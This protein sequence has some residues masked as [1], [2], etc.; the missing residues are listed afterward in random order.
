MRNERLDNRIVEALDRNAKAFDRQAAVVAR[1]SDG[2]RDAVIGLRA[3][4]AKTT[5][6][7]EA[8]IGALVDL[9]AE[10]RR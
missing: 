8:I 10:I 3:H 9:A 6:D 4:Q 2:L 5:G 7:I 1:H